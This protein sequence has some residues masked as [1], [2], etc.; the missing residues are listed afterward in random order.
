MIGVHFNKDRAEQV[1]EALNTGKAIS[2]PPGGWSQN[3]MLALAGVLYAGAVSHG[4]QSHQVAG[5]TPA[6]AREPHPEKQ[7]AVE[8]TFHADLHD[9]IDFMGMLTFKVMDNDFDAD[10]DPEVKAAVFRKPDGGKAVHPA[11]GFKGHKDSI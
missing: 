1:I 5:V 7:E 9:A 6:M 2:A 11:K 4:P 8:D 3:D 10:F